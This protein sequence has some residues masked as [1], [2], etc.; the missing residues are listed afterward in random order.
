MK[1]LR[2]Y[3]IVSAILLVAYLVAQYYK[4]KPTDWTPT[5][6]KEHK[7]PFGTFILH[8][9]IRNIFPNAQLKIANKRA[10]NTLK[11]KAHKNAVY[12]LIA[13]KIDL[14][15]LDLQELMK[16][17]SS[18]NHVFIASFDIANILSDTLK[19]KST[20]SYNYVNKKS[21]GINFTNPQ[22]KSR[23]A[24]HFKK[25]LGDQYFSEFDTARAIVLGK[26]E[27]GNANFLKY[28]FG[29]GALYILP[30]PQL[31]TNYSLLMPS[32]A[33]YATKALSHLPSS[34]TLIWDEF[35]TK[36]DTGDT[37]VLRVI[38]RNEHLRWAYYLAL[39]G[40]VIFVIFEMK[41]RQRIIP[42]VAPLSNSSVDFVKVVGQ[43]YYQQR[44]NRDIANKKS[45]YFLEHIRSTYHFKTAE[46]DEELQEKLSIRSGVKADTI[47]QLFKLIK[48]ING[49]HKVDDQL[50]IDFNKLTEQFYKQAQ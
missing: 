22:L 15:K 35:N 16:F 39:I 37:S 7:I 46:L 19:L 10:Y 8:Q 32:G 45:S 31:L 41:R 27:R 6:L 43:V 25:G 4:P 24:Y 5:Y 26:N 2:R 11:D 3:L 12:L 34:E 49:S 23:N 50:L 40:L 9:Q 48:Q 47:N 30:N 36:P 13:S 29:R 28:T 33:D 21:D 20:S 14:D 42:I 38:F 44:D 18:G 17:M 1:G